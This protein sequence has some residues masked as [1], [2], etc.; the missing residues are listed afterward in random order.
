MVIGRV[1]RLRREQHPV[2]PRARGAGILVDVDQHVRGDVLRAPGARGAFPSPGAAVHRPDLLTPP[3][4]PRSLEAAEDRV[5][6]QLDEA[7]D[8]ARVDHL[9]VAEHQV[10]DL[11]LRVQGALLESSTGRSPFTVQRR[12]CRYCGI[13]IRE[14]AVVRAALVPDREVAGAPAPPRVEVG[15]LDVT[16]QE[17]QEQRALVVVHAV[18]TGHER[19]GDEQRVASGLRD[20]CAPADARRA[21]TPPRPSRRDRRRP[22]HGTRRRSPGSPCARPTAGGTTPASA[23]T[24]ASRAA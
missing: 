11:V 3:P 8:V 14:R 12:I 6:E 23:G 7:V 18:D 9:A 4:F 17:R 15:V 16:V 24:S 5:G 21:G 1:G 22:G 10:A 20:A 13:V 2:R 19:A